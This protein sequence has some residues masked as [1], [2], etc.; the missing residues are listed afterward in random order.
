MGL[1]GASE[2]EGAEPETQL[3]PLALNGVVSDSQKATSASSYNKLLI[4]NTKTPY[5]MT[6]GFCFSLLD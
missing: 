1:L 5:H 6:G 2:V 4:N 3:S